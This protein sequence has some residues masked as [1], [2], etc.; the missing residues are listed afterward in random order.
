MAC[1]CINKV[2]ES[3]EPMN[4]QLV[5]PILGPQKASLQIE[6]II[7]GPGRRLRTH[8]FATYCPF[9]GVKY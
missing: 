4:A 8:L 3:L 7:T 2:N 6:R 5:L 9:C 1:D